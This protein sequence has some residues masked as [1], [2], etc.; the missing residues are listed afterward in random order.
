MRLSHFFIDR[1]IFA[2]VISLIIL[3]IGT[4]AYLTLPVAQFPEIVPPTISVT[5]S[6][7]GANAVTVS[8]TVASVIEQ[9]VNGVEGMIYMYSQ[10]TDDG[11][12]SLSVTFEIGT[13][14]DKAQVLVQN[15][16]FD[17]SAGNGLAVSD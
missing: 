9:E 2:S 11:N 4:I 10:S 1:P 15:R 7:P 5:T 13:D 3:I 16:I 6:Y 17:L 14:V 12:M 8:D